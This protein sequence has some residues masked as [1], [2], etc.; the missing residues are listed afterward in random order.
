MN[1]NQYHH[2]NWKQTALRKAEWGDPV[3]ICTEVK[4]SASELQW[5]SF[6]IGMN[7]YEKLKNS[8]MPELRTVV[9]FGSKVSFKGTGLATSATCSG[10]LV[11]SS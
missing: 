7:E 5:E 4:E 3:Y 6:L 1:N 10:E 2:F 11:N 8:N 9:G